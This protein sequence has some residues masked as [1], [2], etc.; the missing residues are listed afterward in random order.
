MVKKESFLNFYLFLNKLKMKIFRIASVLATLYT[1]SGL[2]G[3]VKSQSVSDTTNTIVE[4]AEFNTDLEYPHLLQFYTTQNYVGE[5]FISLAAVNEPSDNVTAELKGNLGIDLDI[6]LIKKQGRIAYYKISSQ[7]NLPDFIEDFVFDL[8]LKNNDNDFEGETRYYFLQPNYYENYLTVFSNSNQDSLIGITRMDDVAVQNILVEALGEDYFPSGQVEPFSGTID[9]STDPPATISL[10]ERF[11][12]AEYGDLGEFVQRTLEGMEQ[13]SLYSKEVRNRILYAA[14]YNPYLISFQ[15]DISQRNSNSIN[16]K[17]EDLEQKIGSFYVLSQQHSTENQRKYP[18]LEDTIRLMQGFND[19]TYLGSN[20]SPEKLPQNNGAHKMTVPVVIEVSDT[21]LDTLRVETFSE[22]ENIILNEG[23]E[24]KIE[25]IQDGYRV[26]F[27]FDF[28]TGED[29]E[30]PSGFKIFYGETGIEDNH[31]SSELPKTIILYQN[32]PNPFNPSTTLNYDVVGE[33]CKHVDLDIYNIRGKH[34]KT[35]VDE[36]RCPGTHR[37]IWD[38]KDKYGIK[39]SGIYFST[40]KI[41][42]ETRT[43]KMILS[44]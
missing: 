37:V 27:Y 9:L 3:E 44:K 42:D 35:L 41:D 25:Q 12:A 1:L 8:N 19:L 6:E 10:L 7:E 33:E 43:N 28:N 26:T 24:R 38:G 40:L 31:N 36:E 18:D 30:A 11:E 20:M 39:N 32:Y 29:T 17:R 14:E 2:S 4:N 16:Q 22:D 15:V 5:P 34:V 21:E 13:N 23:R